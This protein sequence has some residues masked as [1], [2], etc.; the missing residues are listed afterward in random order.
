MRRTCKGILLLAM[1]ILMTLLLFACKG[2]KIGINFIVDGESYYQI[3]TNGEEEITMPDPP[4]KEGYVFKG[5]FFDENIW[6]EQFTIFSLINRPLDSVID[7]YAYFIT[8]EEADRLRIVNFNS[9]GTGEIKSVETKVGTLIEEPL[10]SRNGYLFSGWFTSPDFAAN[11]KWDFAKNTVSSDMT[12]YAKWVEDIP[13]N[14]LYTVSFN[15]NGGSSVDNITDVVYNTTIMKPSN[16]TRSGYALVG[17][18]TDNTFAKEWNFAFDTV[19]TNFTLYAKWERADVTAC[20]IVSAEGFTISADTLYI[21]TP[22]AQSVFNF[23]DKIQVS[24][25]ASW[26]VV[27]DLQGKDVVPSGNVE[28]DVGDNTKYILVSSYDGLHKKFYTV[29]IRRRPTYSVTLIHNNGTEDTLNA[30]Y[31]E[32]A[33]IDF[34]ELELEGYTLA[35]W[36]YEEEGEENVWT[37]TDTVQGNITLYAKWTANEYNVTFDSDGGNDIVSE[38]VVFDD[39]FTFPVPEK[40]GYIFNGWSYRDE[41]ITDED[42]V[43]LSVWNIAEDSTL[44]AIW[45]EIVYTITYANVKG[46]ENNNTLSYTITQSVVFNA[47]AKDGYIFQKWLDEEGE[48][49]SDIA[50]GSVGNRTITADW[51]LIGYTA[52]FKVEGSV[53]EEIPFTVETVSVTEPIITDKT[54]YTSAWETYSFPAHDITVNA[55]Y[56]PIVYTIS[57]VNVVGQYDVDTPV[58][59]NVATYTIESPT[60]TLSN[61]SKTAYTFDGWTENDEQITQILTGSTGNRTIVANWTAIEYSIEYTGLTGNYD[62]DVPVNENVTTYTVE[63]A[64]IVLTNAYKTGY[65]FNGW[66]A[67]GSSI[68]QIPVKSYG[69]KTIN[70]NWTPFVYTITYEGVAGQYDVDTPVN[71]NEATYTIESPTITL[72]N[73]SKTAYTFDGWTENDEPITK[74]P[75]NSYGNKTIRAN[76]SAIVYNITFVMENEHGDYEGHYAEDANPTTYTIEDAFSFIEPVS[77]IRGYT[78]KGWY[79]TK[80]EAGVKVE[81]VNHVY[82]ART[83]YA[84][85]TR[86]EYTISYYGIDHATNSNLNSYNLETPT[87]TLEEPTKLGYSFLGWYT[88]DEYDQIADTTIEVGSVGNLSFYAKWELTGYSI[89]YVLYGGTNNAN[90]PIAY[91]MEDSVVFQA[92]TR[93]D[94]TF[95]GWFTNSDFATEITDIRTGTTGNVTIYA[96]WYWIATVTFNSNGGSAVEAKKQ[97]YGTTLTA[98]TAPTR[99]YYIFIG[100][101]SNLEDEDPYVFGTMPDVDFTLIAKWR[102]VVYTINYYLNGGVNGNNP[103]TYTVEDAVILE[104]ASKTGHDF[105]AWFR[106]AGFTSEP[107]DKIT[108]GT[109]GTIDL[110]A[111]YSINEYTISFNSNGGSAVTSITQDYDTFVDEPANPAKTGYGFVGWYL[112]NNKYTFNRMPAEDITLTA[113]WETIAYTIS[114]GLDGGTNGNNP[115]SYTIESSTITFVG[116]T[117]RGYTFVGWFSGEDQVTQI[118]HGSYGTVELQAHYEIINYTITYNNADESNTNPATYTVEDAIIFTDIEKLGH[119]YHGLFMENTFVNQKT[120]ITQGSIGNI[121]LYAKYTVNS[122]DLWMD[123]KENPEYIVSFNTVGGNETYEAQTISASNG[124][125]YPGSP[126]KDGYIFAGWYDNDEYTGTSFVFDEE[127]NRNVTLFAKW[128]SSENNVISVNDSVNIAIT[129]KTELLYSFI[130]LVSGDISVTTA[131]SIDTY[132]SL[133]ESETLVKQDDDNGSDSN[134]LIKYNVT[135]GRVY[136]VSVRGY[137]VS[138]TGNVTLSVS[139]NATVPA[140]GKAQEAGNKITVTFGESFTLSTPTKA[141]YVFRGW[142]DENG[143]MYTDATGA[144]IKNFDKGEETVVYSQWD[145]DGFTVSFVTNGGTAVEDDVLARGAR[146]DINR[147]VTTRANY[148]FLGWY[149]SVSDAESYNASVMPDHD[150]TLY[151]RWTS[152]ALNAIKYDEAVTYVS[153]YKEITADDFGA[154]CFDNGGNLVPLTVAISGTQEAGNTITVRFTATNSG[155]TK[156]A[157]ITGVQVYGYPTL[158]I[159][160]SKDYFNLKDGLTAAWFSATA[161]DTYDTAI[162]PVVYIDGD[163]AAGDT[164][165][166]KIKA[167]DIAGNVAEQTVEN[168]KVYGS[169]VISSGTVT[170]IKATDTLTPELLAITAEDSFGVDLVPTTTLYSGTQNAGNTIRVKLY[171]VDSKGNETTEYIDVKVYGLPTISAQTVFDFKVEDVITPA[172]LE[173]SATDSHGGEAVVAIELTNGTQTA[174]QTLTFAVTATDIVGNV[175][176]STVTAK[177]YG[178]PVVT[179]NRNNVLVN[180]EVYAPV[181]SYSSTLSFDLNGGTSGK[182]ADQTI[183]QSQGMT[184]PTTVPTR[185]GYVFKGWYTTSACTTLFDFTSTLTG[186]TT[187][188]AGWVSYSGAGILPLNGTVSNI[189]APSKSSTSSYKYYAF[190]PLVSGNVTV[191]STGSRDSYGYLYNSGKT[192]LASDDDSGSNNNFSMT[193][194][195]TAGTLYYVAPCA[196]DSSNITLSLCMSGASYP[197]AGGKTTA[198]NAII[199]YVN[200]LNATATD[201]FGLSLDVDVTVKSGDITQKAT[202]VT[203][204]ITATDHLGNTTTITT[205]ALGVYDIEDVRNS[206]T[207]N[208]FNTDKIKLSSHGEE[209]DAEAMD[210]FGNACV[211]TIKKLSGATIVAG[212]TQSIVIVATDVAGNE[213]ISDAISNIGVYDVPTITYDSAHISYETCFIESGE[214]MEFLFT[215]HDSFGEE[216]YVTLSTIE[217]TSEYIKVS[218]SVTDDA[219]NHYVAVYTILK[220]ELGESIAVLFYNGVK[221][222]EQRIN[223]GDS[224]SLPRVLVG[225]TSEWQYNSSSITDMNGNSLSAWD[226]DSGIYQLTAKTTIITYTVT[227]NLNGGIN[228]NN[229]SSFTIVSVEGGIALSDPAKVTLETTISEDLGNGN[230]RITKETTA[231]TFL[232]W[233]TE[234]TFDNEVTEITYTGSNVVLYAKWSETTSTT[235]T[236]ESAYSSEGNYIYFGEYPQTIKANNVTITNTTNEKG[237]YLG[238]DGY[239]YAIVTASPYKSGYT[240]STGAS[241]TSGTVYYFKVEPIKWRILSETNGEMFILCESII[242]NHRYA[243][244]SN[245]YANSEIRAWLNDTFYNTAFNDLQKEII[246]LTTVDNSVRSTNPNNNATEFNSGNNSYAC[247]DTQDRVFLLSEQEVTNSAYGFNADYSNYDTARRMQTS[248]YS[249]ATGAYMDMSTDYYGNG[250]WWLRSPDYYNCSYARG[251]GSYGY[252]DYG[253]SVYGTIYGVV[254]ALRIKL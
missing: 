12:L 54:G 35:E 20:D 80:N 83:Y 215:G 142:A 6:Q 117:K 90:N 175:A 152:Y 5:W 157:T 163:Y 249:R 72:S 36:T 76:W 84:Q 190:V 224:F 164:V 112:G 66:T 42:G 126:T 211:I 8:Q 185:S 30:T 27:N 178:A 145:F 34:P 91:T 213:V 208:A 100:W 214:D 96:K 136:T 122:Y 235:T 133:Y 196:Y 132:G 65:T 70:A 236:T 86:E 243:Y 135:A 148:S 68:T 156:T 17:W 120:G 85:W 161:K 169:P 11:T 229:P 228:G 22:N 219:Q 73:A 162:T 53:V 29:T 93:D 227:Y 60:I 165:T 238:S 16:P 141:G 13:E 110:Y 52:T 25:F 61:A 4:E 115:A 153:Q 202:Y 180:E 77:D 78:F 71:N 10:I 118:P 207:Y 81:N 188:Y 49:I 50:V 170:A 64:T 109:H 119:T 242:A 192:K 128:V 43:S 234:S 105:V 57:Y 28:I 111:N 244:S 3:E 129:G 200:T 9:M 155:K 107:V 241:V 248:D 138:T 94:Y 150:V 182:P 168:V 237:Y 41:V 140:G 204:D 167:T 199:G 69:N 232:G 160:E 212:Q 226:K 89:E 104:N 79:T 139:G 221:V 108:V 143:V 186:D 217:E 223:K 14:R 47:L 194:S 246:Q 1:I 19:K 32:D 147:Y 97:A 247:E 87:F 33:T 38:S 123:G 239:Y 92:P 201:S 177:I 98:P 74:I 116:A 21:K 39:E 134:F 176:T 197:S 245:N 23:L 240:F 51:T 114:Y 173:L 222:G 144:S 127:V 210:S 216:L 2:I 75:S 45:E 166:V 59:N 191:Y 184:Y 130:P 252:A 131:G 174:G 151:A 193:Y 99:D 44:K 63:S 206:L 195:V 62:V 26:T 37:D 82:G 172:S 67:N 125:S 56:T 15:A 102:P 31:E 101:F 250:R 40:R 220:L 187:V 205:T 179:Y 95:G 254:P 24:A 209:F 154:T 181:Y 137:S 58:N 46:A 231:Y 251:V 55:I 183:T 103:N 124:L 198:N 113:R 159:G 146:L 171:A 218:A 48:E 7:V 149:L 18:Y 88:S 233:Y 203:Y 121:I 230:Y 158:T 106:D 189:S 253:Y 225:Y